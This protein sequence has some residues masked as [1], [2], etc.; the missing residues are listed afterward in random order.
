[1]NKEEY[2]NLLKK[3]KELRDELTNEFTFGKIEIVSKL[4]DTDVYK[5]LFLISSIIILGKI[6]N[7][8]TYKKGELYV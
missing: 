6:Y 3:K 5:Y 4:T 2:D 7:L 1:M 8:L